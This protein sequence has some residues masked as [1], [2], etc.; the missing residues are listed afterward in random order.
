M[1]DAA[2][3]PAC[4]DISAATARIFDKK[5]F[6]MIDTYHTSVVETTKQRLVFDKAAANPLAREN[7]TWPVWADYLP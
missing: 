3:I 2:E 7:H 4:E 5:G 1:P 6:Q